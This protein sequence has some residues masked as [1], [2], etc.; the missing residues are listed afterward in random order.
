M[1][2]LKVFS[3]R[4]DH[5]ISLFIVWWRFYLGFIINGYSLLVQVGFKIQT[6][7]TIFIFSIEFN[8]EK[9]LSSFYFYTLGICW[10]NSNQRTS[11]CFFLS[12]PSIQIMEKCI[13]MAGQKFTSLKC[14]NYRSKAWIAKQLFLD[15]SY[16][17]TDQ[18]FVM[19]IPFWTEITFHRND[20]NVNRWNRHA[21]NTLVSVALRVYH[22]KENQRKFNINNII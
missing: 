1:V 10:E 16:C 12:L 5:A 20:R 8:F 15:A 22:R 11:F 6:T 13:I 4:Y 19:S 3:S 14:T 9:R 7:L 21:K 2:K 18:D 17:F